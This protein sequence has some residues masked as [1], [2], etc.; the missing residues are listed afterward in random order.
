L[1]FTIYDLGAAGKW[2]PPANRKSQI[3]QVFAAVAFCIVTADAPMF[4]RWP[5]CHQSTNALAM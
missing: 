1:R 5:L 4:G 2:N 3:L